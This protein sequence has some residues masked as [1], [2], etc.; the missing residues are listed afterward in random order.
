M[1]VTKRA[2]IGAVVAATVAFAGLG[3]SAA[4]AA[5]DADK[6]KEGTSAATARVD[7]SLAPDRLAKP[8]ATASPTAKA[9]L[10]AIQ[11]RIA[12]YVATNGTAYSFGSYFDAGTGRIV[13]ETDAPDAVVSSLTSTSGMT[14]AQAQVAGLAQV[15]RTAIDDAFSRRDDVPNFYGGGGITQTAGTPWC[16][17]GFTVQNSAGTRF[18]VTAGHCFANG[19]TVLT[20]SGN[21]T[22]GTVS[23]RR[24]P[25][26]TG[27]AQDMELIGG[28]GYWGRVF[29]GG[30]DSST[31][32]PVVAAGTAFEGFNN[33]CTSGRT[34]G[35]NCGHTATDIDGQ[36]CTQT[37]C[38]S[39]VIVYNGGILP[40]GGDS[41]GAFYVKDSSGNIWIR[42]HHIAG[43]GGTSYATPWLETQA[44]YG[45]SIVL[46]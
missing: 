5:P 20:E 44:A 45:V 14:T 2:L 24:L 26:V 7:A 9:A 21:R 25:T 30:V 3:A 35:E 46:G 29:T 40:Q 10:A 12:K 6:G 36:V 41:G 34:T 23:N 32:A 16:S 43:G 4:Q 33:Y 17:S 8:K 11:K 42:G 13:V 19:V 22:Y 39:P 27:H 31:S 28:Q 38:K 37:G 18:M 1:L 15:R